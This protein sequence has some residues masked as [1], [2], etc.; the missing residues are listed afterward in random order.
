MFLQKPMKAE[1]SASVTCL[2]NQVFQKKCNMLV[3]YFQMS[4]FN[5]KC[6][7]FSRNMELSNIVMKLQ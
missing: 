3:L 4:L 5:R 6:H 7:C 1:I 2:L